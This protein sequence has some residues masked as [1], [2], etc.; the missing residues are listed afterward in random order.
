MMESEKCSYSLNKADMYIWL[1]SK[2]MQICVSCQ[3]RQNH[4][5][6]TRADPVD[7]CGGLLHKILF[8]ENE[9]G[10]GLNWVSMCICMNILLLQ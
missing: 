1:Y 8:L 10:D 9:E 5:H 2:E 4:W 6:C 7:V 3:E